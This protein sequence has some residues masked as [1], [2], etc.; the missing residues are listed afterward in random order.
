VGKAN[1]NKGFWADKKQLF[2]HFSE[3]K[4][5]ADFNSKSTINNQKR[6]HYQRVNL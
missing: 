4:K 5:T 2:I 6:K 3:H 1:E